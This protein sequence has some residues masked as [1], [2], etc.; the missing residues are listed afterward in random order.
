MLYVV[1]SVKVGVPFLTHVLAPAET[2]IET[3][4]LSAMLTFI[5][6]VLCLLLSKNLMASTADSTRISAFFQ[7]I[8]KT[9]SWNGYFHVRERERERLLEGVHRYFY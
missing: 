8:L 7:F 3:T 1:A 5:P 9:S 6:C 4:A 2:C